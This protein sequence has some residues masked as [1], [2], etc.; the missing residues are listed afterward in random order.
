LKTICHEI[1][2]TEDGIQEMML[3]IKN[4]HDE[5]DEERRRTYELKKTEE[6]NLQKRKILQEL[7]EQLQKEQVCS[8]DRL[9][10]SEYQFMIQ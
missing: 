1:T 3:K 8:A 4:L 6:A 10:F 5:E 2:S 7:E 9:F